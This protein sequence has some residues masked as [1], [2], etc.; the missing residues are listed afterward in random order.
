MNRIALFGVAALLMMGSMA[1]AQPADTDEITAT[2]FT[3]ET[4]GCAAVDADVIGTPD[5]LFVQEPYW[6]CGSC[7]AAACQSLAPG[8]YCGRS[9]TGVKKYCTAGL[10][11]SGEGDLNRRCF[12]LAI[13]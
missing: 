13:E 6:T 11:C 3:E 4:P 12:C 9:A 1:G 8:S 5:P 2:I 10:A 7:S